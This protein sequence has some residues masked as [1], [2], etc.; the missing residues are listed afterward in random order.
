VALEEGSM[1]ENDPNPINWLSDIFGKDCEII[2]PPILA[3]VICRLV[4]YMNTLLP[5]LADRALEGAFNE[6]KPA[7]Q[8]LVHEKPKSIACVAAMFFEAYFQESGDWKA[9][10]RGL[11]K[12][13]ESKAHIPE[14]V[15]RVVVDKIYEKKVTGLAEAIAEYRKRGLI[16]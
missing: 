4:P 16:K 5:A 10:E 8:Q 14:L 12:V 2:P 9:M 1:S 13:I 3:M 15:S 11:A 6:L 7:L